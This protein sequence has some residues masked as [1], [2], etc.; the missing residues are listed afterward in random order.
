MN[1]KLL[2]QIDLAIDNCRAVKTQQTK[3]LR[4]NLK[5]LRIQLTSD[6]SFHAK[7]PDFYFKSFD[8]STESIDLNNNLANI[9]HFLYYYFQ[10]DNTTQK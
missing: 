3:V 10:I 9:L 5:E 6:V 8:I 4:E 7:D 1:E 2:E